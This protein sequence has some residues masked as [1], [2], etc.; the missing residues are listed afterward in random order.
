[1]GF[2]VLCPESGVSFQYAGRGGGVQLVSAT[3]MMLINK[4]IETVDL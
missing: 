2:K 1:M 3:I 4:G